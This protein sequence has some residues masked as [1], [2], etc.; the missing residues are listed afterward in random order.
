MNKHGRFGVVT[1]V[2]LLTATAGCRPPMPVVPAPTKYIGYGGEARKVD[3]SFLRPGATSRDE[4]LQRLG[5]SDTGLRL[6]GLFWGRWRASN[7]LDLN[8][9]DD[10]R[11]LWR[12]HNV[13][14]E[15][16]AAGR[17]E[18]FQEFPDTE[19]A[20][21]AA[22]WLSPS[23]ASA[24]PPGVASEGVVRINGKDMRFLL[25]TGAIAI[26]GLPAVPLRDVTRFACTGTS[27]SPSEVTLSLEYTQ[28]SGAKG[29]LDFE[30]EIPDTV[31][32]IE[33]LR[34]NRPESLR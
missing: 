31:P 24:A 28:T 23:A 26:Q 21:V 22:K 7:F 30:A 13:L 8:R 2:A 20:P 33:Y 16:N 10:Q 34:R 18:R 17:V 29:R 11:I 3:L 15:F 1:L 27:R 19:L 32:I 14:V 6:P 12:G 4:M 25:G 5:W 9:Y